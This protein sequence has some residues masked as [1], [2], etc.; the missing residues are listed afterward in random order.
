MRQVPMNRIDLLFAVPE[1]CADCGQELI[2]SLSLD[3][4]MEYAEADM[5][6]RQ[7]FL[8]C[9]ESP[10]TLADNILWRQEIMRDLTSGSLL[11]D[12]RAQ[13]TL[14]ANTREDFRRNRSHMRSIERVSDTQARSSLCITAVAMRDTLKHIRN[15]SALLS[16]YKLYSRGLTALQTRM[17]E[18]IGSR[19]F[20]EL[21]SMAGELSDLTQRD[22]YTVS[23][24]LNGSARLI[25]RQIT[26]IE[27]GELKYSGGVLKRM[28]NR[29]TLVMPELSGLKL[30]GSEEALRND[31]L[32]AALRGISAYLSDIT[33]R[34]LDEF[35]HMAEQLRFYSAGMAY[36]RLMNQKGV[37]TCIP[38]ITEERALR[39]RGLR[40]L[41]LCV[42]EPLAD[43]VVSNDLELS[44][45]G[46]ILLRGENG[47]GKTVY[48]R[49]AG[50]AQLLGQSGLCIT[51]ESASLGPRLGIYS[52]FASSEQGGE[53][54][55][56][57]GRFEQEVAELSAIIERMREKS[58]ILLNETF[59]T[60]SY[61]EGSEGLS[62]I[63]SYFS[64]RGVS[65]M[66]VTHLTELYKNYPDP[67]VI[68]LRT[69]PK[70]FRIVAES[71]IH[72]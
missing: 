35:A 63:L 28:M 68:R 8:R 3:R 54:G 48:L 13:L 30:S 57:A 12:L 7:Y 31:I 9:L 44:E 65:W 67:D 72:Q 24:A 32:G 10:P 37:P 42:S 49:S 40:D 15:I 52:Q 50:I 60:T 5:I 16:K 47:S 2:Y 6:S 53:A 21:Q 34:L 61:P 62:G 19:A 4:I 20:A 41:W 11:G 22:S 14:L 56:D 23:V 66:L 38:E 51:A 1:E 70:E 59:Q 64:R 25:S 39:C 43:I 69:V 58:L 71:R 55:P 17:Q 36:R 45:C 26:G 18:I 46:G 27:K 29:P 33:L